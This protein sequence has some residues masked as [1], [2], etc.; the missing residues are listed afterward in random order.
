MGG[1]LRVGVAIADVAHAENWRLR[2]L[3]KIS[4]SKELELAAFIAPKV[5]GAKGEG[6]RKNG[7]GLFAFLHQLDDRLLAKRSPCDRTAI[8]QKLQPV[9]RIDEDRGEKRGDEGGLLASPETGLSGLDIIVWLEQGRPPRSLAKAARFGVWWLYPADDRIQRQGPPGF[10]ESCHQLPVSGLTLKALLNEEPGE[11][12]DC[13]EPG[14]RVVARAFFNTKFSAARNADFIL[15]KAVAFIMRQLRQLAIAGE[16]AT[17]PAGEAGMGEAGLGGA[18]QQQPDAAAMIR[19][20]AGL[21]GSLARR[22]SDELLVKG[23][24]RP[25][26]WTLM[27]GQRP[28]GEAINGGQGEGSG[29]PFSLASDNLAPDNLAKL[30]EARPNSN[31]LWGDPFLFEKDGRTYVFFENYNYAVGVANISVGEL[32]GDEFVFLGDVLNTGYHLSYP[33]IFEEQGEIYMMPESYNSSRL[34]VWKCASFPFEWRLHATAFEG[35]HTVDSILFRDEDQWWLFTNMSDEPYQDLC[36]ELYLF[37]VDGPDL[38]HIE[39]H[40]LNP[41]VIDTRY[42]RNGGRVF[43]SG[44]QLYRSSQNNSHG[45]YGYGVNLMRIDRLDLQNYSETPVRQISPD[46]KP[47]LVGCHHMDFLGDRF[48]IDACRRYGGF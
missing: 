34:E 27:F 14:E 9:K 41:V 19:Y 42:A 24:L 18:Q 48:V 7:S 47:G 40:A 44:G 2:L 1:R 8:L 36:S 38:R 28:A 4:D 20:G 6:A 15:E 5:G 29:G 31:E 22:A 13:D 30:I 17:E 10:W 43:R 39:P 16:M 12:R 45:V 33:F 21:A 46:F 37:A 35:Q 25:F 32:V 3:E 23:R 11:R 26:M